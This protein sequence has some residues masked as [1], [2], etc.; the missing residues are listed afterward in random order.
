MMGKAKKMNNKKGINTFT[1][2]DNEMS[3]LIVLILVVALVFAIFYVITLLVTGKDTAETDVS[4]SENLDVT[5]QY[6]K[7]LA[8]N[9]LS[10][11]NDEYYVLAYFNDDQYLNFYK[12]Y[13]DFYKSNV[14]GSVPYYF[15]DLDEV[16]NSSFVSD[17]SNL[18]FDSISNLKFSQTTLLRIKDGQ[19][20]STYEGNKQISD[21][22]GRMTK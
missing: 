9:V 13:L 3:K 21:K 11:K 19:I 15:I 14:D 18:N 12:S 16:F 6:Q 4:N 20:I 2:S 8:G 7:I 1:Y 5:I 17:E 10:Q 22:L